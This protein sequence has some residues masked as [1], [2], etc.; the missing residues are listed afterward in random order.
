MWQVKIEGTSRQG[1]KEANLE[2]HEWR[3][4]PPLLVARHAISRSTPESR[5]GRS[6]AL[7][8]LL[9]LLLLCFMFQLKHAAAGMFFLSSLW[10][11]QVVGEA[12]PS[13]V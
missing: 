12:E 10:Q 3:Y 13:Q 4:L 2:R 11:Q 6:S 1:E 8:F 9:L 7:F 5:K